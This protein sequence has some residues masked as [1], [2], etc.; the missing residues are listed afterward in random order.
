[1]KNIQHCVPGLTADHSTPSVVAR[2]ATTERRIR[3]SGTPQSVL[4]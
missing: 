4:S 2:G 1:M 3:E